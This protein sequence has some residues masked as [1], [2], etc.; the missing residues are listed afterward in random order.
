VRAIEALI[1]TAGPVSEDFLP[2]LEELHARVTD[3][4]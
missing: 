1:A 4:N 2:S 3:R